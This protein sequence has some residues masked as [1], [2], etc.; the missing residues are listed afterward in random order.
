[1]KLRLIYIATILVC[2][3]LKVSGQQLEQ[4]SQ[5]MFNK[6]ILNPAATADKKDLRVNLIYRRQWLGVFDGDEPTTYFISATSRSKKYKN[7]GMGINLYA[8]V[9]GPTRRTGLDLNYAYK[10]D[11]KNSKSELSLGLAANFLQYHLN[12]DALNPVDGSDAAIFNGSNSKIGADIDIGA[13]MSDKNYYAG[14]S[15]SQLFANKLVLNNDS[16]GVYKLSR[17]YYLMG[18]YDYDI[19]RDTKLTATLLAKNTEATKFQYEVGAIF[20]F[21]KKYWFGLNYRTEDAISFLAGLEFFNDWKFGYSYDVT[22]S[23]L[24][25]VSNGAHELFLSYKFDG[26]R[27]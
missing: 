9:T 16:V 19:D 10:I 4:Y 21:N 22:I 20:E 1:M 12:T 18:G 17:H 23:K 14:I 2:F 27:L 24:N 26:L 7:I 25:A 6:N 15:V 11:L 13:F 3:S 8:D 5:Y